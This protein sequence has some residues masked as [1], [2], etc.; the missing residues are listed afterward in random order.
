MLWKQHR[1]VILKRQRKKKRITDE[2]INDE[3]NSSDYLTN[4]RVNVFNLIMD[5]IVQLL[6]S[7]FAQQKQLSKDLSCLDPAKFKTI[8]EKGLEDEALEGII[9]LFPQINNCQVAIVFFCFK[10]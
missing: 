2:F 8:T 10:L 5:H 6:E 9:K 7:R 4:F 3:G 1:H